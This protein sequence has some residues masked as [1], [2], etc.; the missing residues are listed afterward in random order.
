MCNRIGIKYLEIPHLFMPGKVAVDLFVIISG[1]YMVDQSFRLQKLINMMGQ[2]WFYTL[3]A[4][5]GFV[6]I[7][8][9]AM[10]SMNLVKISVLSFVNSSNKDALKLKNQIRDNVSLE[11]KKPIDKPKKT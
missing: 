2:V 11:N 8:G 1:Y 3:S 9:P 6:L 4:L 7:A 5:I 10:L